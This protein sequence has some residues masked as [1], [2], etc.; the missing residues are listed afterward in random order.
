MYIPGSKGQLPLW[1]NKNSWL[2]NNFTYKEI[3][4]RKFLGEIN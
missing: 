3:N 2:E 1:Y 4:K